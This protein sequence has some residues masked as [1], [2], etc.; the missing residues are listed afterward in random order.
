MVS[1]EESRKDAMLKGKLVVAVALVAAASGRP[2]GA[3]KSCA[4]D[5]FTRA[6]LENTTVRSAERDPGGYCRVRATTTPA[7]NSAIEFEVWIPDKWNGKIVA[8]GN[9]GY[10][11]V[12]NYR[13]MAYALSQGYAAVG[14]DTGHQTQTP[15]DLLWGVGHP[16]RILDWGTRSIHAIT[17][18]AKRIAKALDGRTP[19]R[20]YYYGC[21]TGGHQAYAEIQRYPEDF[22][23]VVAGA[24][25]NN[26]VRL[27]A[28]FL[29]QFLSNRR[30]GDEAHTLIPATKLPAI[31]RA[32]VAA[33]DANDGVID[34]V[35]DDPRDCDFD[36]ASMACTGD[37]DAS[38]LTTAQLAA[39]RKMYAGATNP[40][41]HEQIYP[42]WPKGSEAGWQQYWGTTEPARV[43]FWRYWVFDNP[44]WDPWTFDFDRDLAHADAKVGKMIDQVN[45]DLTAFRRHG[46]RAIVY[47]GWQDP[48]V[49]ALD[50]VGYYERLRGRTGS[51]ADT[52]RFFR[53]FMVPGMSHCAG[54]SGTTSFG[55]Q[56]APSP[57][58]DAE[59]D[60]LSALDAWVE[61]GTPPDRIIASRVVNGSTV[62]TRPL[63]P[64]PRRAVYVGTG[65]ADDA[66]NFVCRAAQRPR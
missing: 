34:G 18:P 27:N 4:P 1:D 26:R 57:L 58:V 5:T 15:D 40:R 14:G 63:C 21:S 10:S 16:E 43:N 37:D 38:C 56:N 65:S 41:T 52:D 22:D 3:S 30:R 60:M 31:T 39:L 36:P 55:N 62:R 32:V 28:G 45:P 48:V 59:H 47:Q 66:A 54:G 7:K 35:L 33:C 42:G 20:A 51:Q 25:G 50:T 64:Y 46:G 19:T 2:S 17:A 24:P 61:R 9:G 12:P 13:D 8:T 49:S 6:K 11:N 29:W 23:G 53:L 44:N